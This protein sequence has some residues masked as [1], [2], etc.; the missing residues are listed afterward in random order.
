MTIRGQGRNYFRPA[1]VAAQTLL[2]EAQL[3][4]LDLTAAHLEHFIACG[5][6]KALDGVVGLEMYL[7]HALLRSLAVAS[8]K[9]G[10]GIGQALLAEA[11]RHAGEQ[12]VREI[13]LLTT[14]AER[15]FSRNSYERIARDEAPA[16]I[17]ATQEFTALCPASAAFMRKRLT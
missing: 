11:E 9:R 15:F 10:N 16:A 12:G 14:T 7:P 13:Y 2:H 4:T 8:A 6:D 3:P 5:S 17:R 1:L